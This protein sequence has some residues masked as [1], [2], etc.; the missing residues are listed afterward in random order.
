VRDANKCNIKR[1]KNEATSRLRTALTFSHSSIRNFKIRNLAVSTL[2]IFSLVTVTL[3]YIAVNGV[4]P[5]AQAAQN[6]E[7]GSSYVRR[8]G[9]NEV[10]SIKVNFAGRI[11]DIIGYNDGSERQVFAKILLHGAGARAILLKVTLKL[12]VLMEWQMFLVVQL[13]QILPWLAI[14]KL[15][16]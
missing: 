15:T 2:V 16:H 12:S 10:Q 13:L 4:V 1:Q 5:K 11:W 14:L 7:C 3:G 6:G 9:T 8:L